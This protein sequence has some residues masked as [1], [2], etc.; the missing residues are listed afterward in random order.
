MPQQKIHLLRVTLS[1]SRKGYTEAMPRQD[2]ESF[3]RGIEN[4][5]RSFEGVAQLLV[6]DNLK[7]G[8]LKASIYDPELNPKF[9]DF[10]KHYGVV[11][12]PTRPRTPEHKGKVENAV[13]YVK[14]GAVKGR[15]FASLYDLNAHL[16]HW[17]RSVADNRIHGT[18]RQQV[19]AHFQQ[20]E[21]PALQ[22]LPVD[23]FPSFVEAKR[24]V[25]RDSYVEFERSYYDVPPEYITREMW[26][27]SDG[28]MVHVLTLAMDPVAVHVKLPPGKFTR[29]LGCGGTP[30]SV[31]ESLQRWEQ[32]AAEI[33]DEVGLWA[34]AL[35]IRR[36]E[37]GLRVLM[38]LVHQL[39]PRYG[40][41]AL[42]RACAQ[43]RVHGQYRLHELKNWLKEPLEQQSFSFLAEHEL[44]RDMDA[45]GQLVGFE[46][47][48]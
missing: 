24:T 29:V 15:K 1:H 7:A 42:E 3:I 34:K 2:T 5:F 20:S 27:R 25:H 14:E 23:L 26:V 46:Q 35:I 32:R 17:E 45:Y 47:N 36:K 48:N 39:L 44:I 28:R 19:G 11:A 8:V 30:K 22:S 43:A 18:T 37:A 40:S 4:A 13:G 10:C 12:L 41:A 21:K 6:L 16:R 31:R 33:G 9:A 38:G